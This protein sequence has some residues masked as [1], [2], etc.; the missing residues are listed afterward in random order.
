MKAK[1]GIKHGVHWKQSSN[2]IFWTV[3]KRRPKYKIHVPL[4][5]VAKE[6]ENFPVMLNINKRTLELNGYGKYH[7][8]FTYH[9]NRIT[10]FT[11]AVVPR[12]TSKRVKKNPGRPQVYF[13][14]ICKLFTCAY[15][16]YEVN[17]NFHHIKGQHLKFL[18]S[19]I[20]SHS[21]TISVP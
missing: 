6:R 20:S 12:G 14:M 4:K 3:V 15:S 2:L 13:H 5:E 16:D 7:P 9:S 8:L 19:S 18:F 21:L 10:P 17:M 1:R 11:K